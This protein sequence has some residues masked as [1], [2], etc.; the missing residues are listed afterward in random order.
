MPHD[1]FTLKDAS[2]TIIKIDAFAPPAQHEQPRDLHWINRRKYEGLQFATRAWRSLTTRN[3]L[4]SRNAHVLKLFLKEWNASA[5]ES[6]E[7]PLAADLLKPLAA[8]IKTRS[9]NNIRTET[10][11]LIEQ[12]DDWADKDGRETRAPKAKE[13]F[14]RRVGGTVDELLGPQP[15]AESQALATP[16]T[17]AAAPQRRAYKLPKLRPAFAR[18]V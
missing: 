18:A 6:F 7:C 8:A 9:I 14:L 2:P 1:V 11:K 17:V 5:S 10:G 12:A 15:L 13:R 4:S 16:H 3:Y